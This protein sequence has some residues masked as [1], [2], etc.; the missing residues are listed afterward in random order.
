MYKLRIFT[1]SMLALAG[2]IV[3]QTLTA[4]EVAATPVQESAT[5]RGAGPRDSAALSAMHM[6]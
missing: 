1:L 3:W 4:P 6:P 5:E 2:A